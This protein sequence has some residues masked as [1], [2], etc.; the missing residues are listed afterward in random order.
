MRSQADLPAQ[1][2]QS[3]YTVTYAKDSIPSSTHQ[4]E[5]NLS[6]Y[7]S[8]VSIGNLTTFSFDNSKRK[9]KNR[10]RYIHTYITKLTRENRSDQTLL[11]AKVKNI[12]RRG[13]AQTQHKKIYVCI[14]PIL[15]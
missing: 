5:D 8:A 13:L 12:E 15:Q 10:C 11:A 7:G 1:A 6:A 3:S 4:E 9:S 2:S 14:A